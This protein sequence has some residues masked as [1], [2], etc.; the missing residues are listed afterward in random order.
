MPT[1]VSVTSL[2]K[3]VDA[4]QLKPEDIAAKVTSGEIEL[5]DD[6]GAAMP[7]AP[8]ADTVQHHNFAGINY[9]FDPSTSGAAEGFGGYAKQGL[10]SVA[11]AG[12]GVGKGAIGTLYHIGR[13]VGAVPKN[14]D[15]EDALKDENAAQVTGHIAE[16]TAEFAGG[17]GAANAILKGTGAAAKIAAA[18]KAVKTV[19]AAAKGA[20]VGGVVTTAQGGSGTTGAIVGGAV[21]LVGAALEPLANSLAESAAKSYNRVL[22]ATKNTMKNL[23]DKVVRG[24]SVAGNDVPGL[25]D[26]GVMAWTRKGLSTEAATEV[27]NLGDQIDNLWSALPKGEVTDA[28]PILDSIES[29]KAHLVQAGPAK[30]MTVPLTAVL[31]TD[32]VTSVTNGVATIQRAQTAVIEP[33]AVRN[34]DRV[35]KLVET[36]TDDNGQANVHDLR[37]VKQ[38]FDETVAAKGGYAGTQLSLADAAGV[39]ARKEAANAIRK[40]L[41]QQYPNIAAINREFNFWSNVQDITNETLRRTAS[42]SQPMGQQIAKV[43]GAAAAGH[44]GAAKAILT[45]ETLST[46]RKL[47]TS[48]AWGTTSAVAKDRLALLLASGQTSRAVIGMRQLM[49]VAASRATQP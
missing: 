25:I 36:L 37:K 2:Q 8:Q 5:H 48:A 45:G 23:S 40:Q 39:R 17:E 27:T 34:L 13:F 22:G 44:A 18:G 46:F 35:K 41:A 4:G 11:E 1:Q 14:Q 43:A 24:Y 28:Q 31:P 32:T 49:G 21:P 30:T 38:I 3:L 6:R 42:Q 15:F 19:A 47:T 7:S 29:A 33:G 10:K 12:L 20:A 9:D 26:R 16:Q